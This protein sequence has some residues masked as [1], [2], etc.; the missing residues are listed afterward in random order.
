MSTNGAISC[1]TEIPYA[2]NLSRAGHAVNHVVSDVITR[3]T[4]DGIRFPGG[5]DG[6]ID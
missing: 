6:Q 3:P 5:R 4:N 1:Q 2:E